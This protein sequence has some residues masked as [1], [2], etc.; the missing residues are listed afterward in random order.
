MSAPK[1]LV[2]WGDGV[3]PLYKP[4]DLQVSFRHIKVCIYV[5]ICTHDVNVV[6]MISFTDRLKECTL[7]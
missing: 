7:W 1:S 6:L 2:L 4:K 3:P 5:Y